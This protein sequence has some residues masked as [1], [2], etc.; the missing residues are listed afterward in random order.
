MP[1][2]KRKRRQDQPLRLA[3]VDP[4]GILFDREDA[5]S[6]L[7]A[8]VVDD[9]VIFDSSDMDGKPRLDMDAVEQLIDWLTERW[10]EGTET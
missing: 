7:R 6:W 9:E 5:D 2:P 1:K 3:S 4:E 8:D 10:Q